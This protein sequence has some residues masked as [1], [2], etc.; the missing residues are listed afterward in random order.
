MRRKTKHN[1]LRAHAS[2]S[3]HRSTFESLQLRLGGRS[4]G[5]TITLRRAYLLAIER[6]AGD[7]VSRRRTSRFASLH[8][9]GDSAFAFDSL[10]RA[11]STE[12]YNEPPHLYGRSMTRSGKGSN[13]DLRLTITRRYTMR[14]LSH[15]DRQFVIIVRYGVNRS[16]SSSRVP[17]IIDVYATMIR[18]RIYRRQ[19]DRRQIGRLNGKNSE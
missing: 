15:K 10:Q 2:R 13:G 17:V 3:G 7:G 12:R 19:I 16:I 1:K 14:L 11:R 8:P 4:I 18:T 9:A 6:T 5:P